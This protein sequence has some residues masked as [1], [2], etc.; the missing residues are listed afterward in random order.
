MSVCLL[1]IYSCLKNFIMKYSY[2]C[3][4]L[5]QFAILLSVCGLL[6][7]CASKQDQINDPFEKFNRGIYSINNKIDKFVSKPIAEVYVK[8]T[9][10]II[11][12]GISNAFS[13]IDD[14]NVAANYFLQLNFPQGVKNTT[15]LVLNS[16]FGLLGIMDVAQAVG[17]HKKQNDLGITLG[18]WGIRNTPYIVIPI[19]GPSTFSDFAGVIVEDFYLNPIYLLDDNGWENAL[20]VVSFINARANLLGSSQLLA[21]GSI[22]GDEY[23]F[24]RSAYITYRNNLIDNVTH[25]VEN[26]TND[27]DEDMTDMDNVDSE[28]T[29][30]NGSNDTDTTKSLNIEIK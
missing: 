27:N 16:T 6:S 20:F 25:D 11:R 4:N 9:P 5:L 7:S 23:S 24:A 10:K 22:G 21:S 26:T 18:R 3:K 1:S 17:L 19:L 30:K 8:A 2:N 14:I 15:R 13:N 12:K 28:S 29:A